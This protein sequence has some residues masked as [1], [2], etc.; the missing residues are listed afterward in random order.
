MKKIKFLAMLLMISLLL[1]ACGPKT[2]TTTDKKEDTK[3]AE[4]TE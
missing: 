1:V 4:S 3:T 2:D